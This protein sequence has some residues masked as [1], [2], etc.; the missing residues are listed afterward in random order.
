MSTDSPPPI[1]ATPSKFNGF[2]ENQLEIDTDYQNIDENT[3]EQLIEI[4]EKVNLF[5]KRAALFQG[6]RINQSENRA[7]LHTALRNI[8]DDPILL[9][10]QDVMPGIRQVW[11]SMDALCNKFV[12]VTDI[13]HIGIGGSDFG[14]RLVCDALQQ[15]SSH[16]GGNTRHNIRLH[17]LAN[18]DSNELSSILHKAQALSTRVIITSK[19]FTTLETMQNAKSVTEWLKEK[20]LSQSQISK[21]TYAVT[22]NTAEAE[23][24]AIPKENIFPFWDWVGGRFSVWSSV[25]LPIALKFGFD[26]FKE[27]LAGAYAMDQH[28]LNAPPRQNQPL[29]LALSLI[30]NQKRFNIKSQALIP[31]ANALGHMPHW[32]QQLD[33][34]SNGK[35]SNTQGKS[36]PL[37]SP[38]IF[39]S[40]GTNAQHSFFQMLHQGPEII[41]VDFIAVKEPMSE[42][43]F[44][45][46]HHQ[47]LL[48]NCLAQAQALAK[49]QKNDAD[50]NQNYPGGRP[51]NLIWL[52]KLNAFNL[53]SLLAL[54]EH[55]A[56]CL[57]VLWGLNSFDQPGVELSKKLAKP[58]QEALAQ[59]DDTELLKNLDKV[60]AKRIQFLKQ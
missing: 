7:A 57:G 33:M 55:R 32:L 39:G 19:T 16:D 29:L 21:H 48:A 15:T 10:G 6:E 47:I 26:T 28:F 20:G 17:F 11:R 58:I 3:W 2:L 34:E 54:Y 24:A 53:G 37:S 40:A 9:D 14:P 52:P 23:K 8:S 59:K 43:P 51:S 13:I 44:A 5:P 12:G 38:V 49:G 41:P 27:F 25:G 42:L 4:A 56:F 18:I 50:L 45:Q 35:T 46:E 22:A 36:A 30:H 60:T 31:Y 1:S